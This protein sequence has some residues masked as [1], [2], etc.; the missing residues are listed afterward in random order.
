MNIMQNLLFDRTEVYE[1]IGRVVAR[2]VQEEVAACREERDATEDLRCC[3]DEHGGDIIVHL[4]QDDVAEQLVNAHFLDAP[5]ETRAFT[6]SSD[7]GSEYIES[8]EVTVSGNAE[9]E[10]T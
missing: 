2:Q 1:A 10:K 6:G 8:A 9:K 5:V 3:A 7:F 4:C